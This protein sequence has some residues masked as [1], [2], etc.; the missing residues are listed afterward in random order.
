MHLVRRLKAGGYVLL[1]TQYVTEH[2]RQFGVVE[3][4]CAVYERRLAEALRVEA[5][6]VGEDDKDSLV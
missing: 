4:P 1:D 2:L 5:H 6:W 3:I